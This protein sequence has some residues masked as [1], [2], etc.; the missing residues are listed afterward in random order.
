MG[1]KR[2]FRAIENLCI[3]FD[4]IGGGTPLSGWR[5]S[6]EANTHELAHCAVMGYLCSSDDIQEY[7]H[8]LSDQRSD[9]RE[10][11]ACAAEF[12]VLQ[13]LEL[14][15]SMPVLGAYAARSNKHIKSSTATFMAIFY[16]TKTRRVVQT[17]ERLLGWIYNSEEEI[18]HYKASK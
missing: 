12:L 1:R 6:V 10:I 18:A 13:A 3:A 14:P 2:E 17:A 9:A 7:H 16:A 5:A 15:V 11:E 8:E 4:C